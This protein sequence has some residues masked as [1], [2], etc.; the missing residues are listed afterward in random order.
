M[1]RIHDV[2]EKSYPPEQLLQPED[3]PSVILN[4]LNLPQTAEVTDIRIRHRS[5][6]IVGFPATISRSNVHR[7]LRHGIG[8]DIA[9]CSFI[10]RRSVMLGLFS[11]TQSATAAASSRAP[12]AST[13]LLLTAS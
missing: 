12:F 5:E 9:L 4:A 10:S 1:L 2:E 7:L 6:L 13:S 11:W 8:S 3:V